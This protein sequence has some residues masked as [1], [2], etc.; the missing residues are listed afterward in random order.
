MSEDVNSPPRQDMRLSTE[1]IQHPQAKKADSDDYDSDEGDEGAQQA[2]SSPDHDAGSC[3]TPSS[4]QGR[5]AH[6]P[7]TVEGKPIPFR[8]L[9][10]NPRL[11]LALIEAV[12]SFKPF[13]YGNVKNGW[14]KVRGC[15]S[16]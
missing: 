2:G 4:S 9:S 12:Q 11:Q 16:E 8:G 3:Q 7:R 13:G 14:K 1:D 6:R 10:R 15:V 5:S